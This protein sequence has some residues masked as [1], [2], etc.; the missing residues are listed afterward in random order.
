MLKRQI[1]KLP[2]N[3]RH[4]EP[5]GEGGVQITGFLCDATTLFRSQEV[6]RPHIVQTVGQLNQN[7]TRVLGNREEQLA[8][9]LNLT[10]LAG[11]QWQ[12]RNLC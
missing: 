8:I 5:M 7:D 1:L 9:V 12:I 4:T 2:S 10:F 6:E 11:G 3:L